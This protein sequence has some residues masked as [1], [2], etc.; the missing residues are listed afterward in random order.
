MNL[1]RTTPLLALALLATS[2]KKTAP[3]TPNY[4]DAIN[5]YYQAHPVCLWAEEKKFP[6]QAATS[7]DAKTQGYDALVDQ[8]LLTRTTSEKRIIIISRQ[9][10]NYDLSPQGHAAWT[11]DVSQP[12]FGNFCFGH[13]KV[14]SID[15]N[16]P[17]SDQPGA[18]VTVNY[19]YTLADVPAWASAQETQTAFPRLQAALSGAQTAAATLTNT[20]QGWQVT[21]GEGASVNPRTPADGRIVQ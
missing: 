21:S 5:A 19:H 20:S 8:G 6:V 7:D 2:C 16:T 15:S 1:F 4:A 3:T 18:T 10:N 12:G 9:E 14:A 11:A 17:A 13:R